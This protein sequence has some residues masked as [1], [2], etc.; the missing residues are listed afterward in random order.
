MY[1]WFVV[2]SK[3]SISLDVTMPNNLPPTFPVF[4]IGIPEK[5]CSAF[6]FRTSLTVWLG[7]KTTGS[8]IKPCLY[9]FT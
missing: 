1:C 5:P 7:D 4:V 8:L 3:K 9:F 6:T 2:L